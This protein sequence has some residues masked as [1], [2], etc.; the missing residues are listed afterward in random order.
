MYISIGGSLSVECLVV[1]LRVLDSEIKRNQNRVQQIEKEI[2][3]NL[4][5]ALT[6]S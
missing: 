2:A 1:D 5:L 4:S 6:L 3:W